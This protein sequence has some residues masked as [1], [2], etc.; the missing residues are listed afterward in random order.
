M[1]SMFDETEFSGEQTA[2][3]L[4]CSERDSLP[5]IMK[6]DMVADILVKQQIRKVCKISGIPLI[7]LT[8]EVNIS[9][10][11]IAMGGTVLTAGRLLRIMSYLRMQPDLFLKP[12][13]QT[14]EYYKR[15]KMIT[16]MAYED[17][18]INDGRKSK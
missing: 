18:D 15:E 4:A 6:E 7:K 9:Q 10:A 17:I 11:Q 5:P 13:M 1:T 3:I 16:K 14:L 8:E 2:N 12:V